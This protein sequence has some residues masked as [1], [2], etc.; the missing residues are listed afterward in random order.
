MAKHDS[1]R[2]LARNQ[3][4][5]LYAKEHP[6]F[7]MKEIGGIFGISASRVWVILNGKRP[8]KG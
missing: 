2:K 1:L 5:K 7:S 3:I 6:D 4:L 8:K